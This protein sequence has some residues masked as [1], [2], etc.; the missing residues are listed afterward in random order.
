MHYTRGP[1]WQRQCFLVTLLLLSY[2]LLYSR[3]QRWSPCTWAFWSALPTPL[4]S[5]CA[6]R[7]VSRHKPP[8]VSLFLEI[9]S[10]YWN[11]FKAWSK[12]HYGG[13]LT[14]LI[15]DSIYF[16]RELIK[17]IHKGIWSGLDVEVS[18]FWAG[19]LAYLKPMTLTLYKPW[20]LNHLI[21]V[22]MIS[23]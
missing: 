19:W 14:L 21:W 3:R 15:T 4:P 5:L 2:A 20:K 6:L 7:E 9:I 23:R 12:L 17:M 18:R 16:H 10:I 8:L 22:E 11:R 1:F 13:W